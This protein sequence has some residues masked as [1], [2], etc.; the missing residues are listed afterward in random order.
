[1][2]RGNKK[3]QQEIAGFVLIVVI[4]VIAMMVFLVISLKKPSLEIKDRKADNLLTSLMTQTTECIVSRERYETVRDLVKDSY[5]NEKCDNLDMMASEYLNESLVSIMGQV[6]RL[7]PTI[8]AYEIK[9]VWASDDDSASSQLFGL[10]RGVCNQSESRIYGGGPEQVSVSDG[11][12][13]VY[14]KLCSN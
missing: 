8:S 9:G 2:I 5:E 11:V 13:S 7:E 6:M 4:V 12:I 10:I 14:L 3:G 1:M